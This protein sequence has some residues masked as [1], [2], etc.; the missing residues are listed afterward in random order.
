MNTVRKYIIVDDDNFNNI[1]CNMAIESALGE[2][3]IKTFEVPEE[4]L[5]FIQNEYIKSLKPTIL[6]LDLNMPT[7]T[8]WNLW[9]NMKNSVK[10]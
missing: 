4:A 9:N 2:V 7:L 3:D 10:K 6:F 5:A 1:I 8:G